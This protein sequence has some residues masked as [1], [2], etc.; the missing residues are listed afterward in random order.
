RSGEGRRLRRRGAL[1]HH[2]A[3]A[4]G[5][6]R[7]GWWGRL[8]RGKSDPDRPDRGARLAVPGAGADH[9]PGDL[10]GRPLPLLLELAARGPAP[11]RHLR[12]SEP[13]TEESA[14]AGGSPEGVQASEWPEAQRRT[15][16]AAA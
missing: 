4:A 2:L 15:S 12:S 13:K 11:V 1:Q 14:L 7:S 5:Y 9:R 16:D 8:D 3:L 10:P 6:P